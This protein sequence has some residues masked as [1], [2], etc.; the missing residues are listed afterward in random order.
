MMDIRYSC[1]YVKHGAV[2]DVV[3]IA[4]S[5]DHAEFGVVSPIIRC[6]LYVYCGKRETLWLLVQ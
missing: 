4:F 1:G 2:P 6:F 3:R 5:A